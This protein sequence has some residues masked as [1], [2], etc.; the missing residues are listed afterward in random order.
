[1]PPAISSAAGGVDVRVEPAALLDPNLVP[2]AAAD[3]ALAMGAIIQIA[4]EAQIVE[5]DLT[6]ALGIDFA[7]FV[8]FPG[9]HDRPLTS[10]QPGLAGHRPS[11]PP[12]R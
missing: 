11:S 4:I 5:T 6:H 8:A 7:D 12:D 9:I 1:M 2:G 10:R 3:A